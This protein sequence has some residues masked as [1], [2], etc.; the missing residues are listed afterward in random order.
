MADQ[1]ISK[2]TFSLIYVTILVLITLINTIMTYIIDYNNIQSIINNLDPK[3]K[4]IAFITLTISIVIT[5]PDLLISFYLY[6]LLIM[7]LIILSKIPIILIIK[8]SLAVIPFVIIIAIFIPFIKDGNPIFKYNLGK[9]SIKIT[10]E[11][12]TIFRT[13]LIKSYLSILCMTLLIA[14]TGFLQILRALEELKIS[15]IIV[16]VFSFMYRYIFILQ[17]ELTKMLL[18]KESRTISKKKWLQIKALSNMLGVLFI[19]SYERGEFVYLA[20]CSRGFDGSIKLGSYKKLNKKDYCFLLAIFTMI[21][22][23]NLFGRY[24]NVSLK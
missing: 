19:R 17:D 9:F 18:A 24:F 15:R 14:S 4:L 21:T 7:I 10:N 6:G 2:L 8:R 1:A 11:G 5:N 3:A 22:C 13:V 23:I 16:M 12:L 20:M